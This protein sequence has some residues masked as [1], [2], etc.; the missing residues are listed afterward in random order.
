MKDLL[1]HQMQDSDMPDASKLNEAQLLQKVQQLESRLTVDEVIDSS[2][3]LL[4]RFGANPTP[5]KAL[6]RFGSEMLEFAAAA[7]EAW[8]GNV[9]EHE[10]AAR[11]AADVIVTALNTLRALRVP[12][13]A[14]IQALREVMASND[15]KSLETHYL[16]DMQ[17]VE[18]RK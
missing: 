11:E 7:H 2:W 15:R 3:G 8:G 18:R 10:K 1:A 4:E 5:K 6:D 14:I 9:A 16:T 12:R 13:E 17:S